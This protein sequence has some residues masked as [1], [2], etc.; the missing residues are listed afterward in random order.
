MNLNLRAKIKYLP[1]VGILL[2]SIWRYFTHRQDI[3][4]D[5][6]TSNR[7][8]N[9]GL[10]IK[11]GANDGSIGD[12]I[13]QLLIAYK[14]LKCV[15]VE[16]VPHLLARAKSI[17]GDSERFKYINN[18]IND[19]SQ[20]NFYFVDSEAQKLQNISVDPEQIG[21]FELSHILKHEGGRFA[22]FV[23]EIL[24]QGMTLQELLKN[25]I[26]VGIDLIHVDAEG[27]DWKIISQ[28]ELEKFR[29]TWIIFEYIHL[30]LSE[31]KAAVDKFSS[32]YEIKEYGTDY[33]C[34]LKKS[35]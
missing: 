13:S 25:Y 20:M 10:I 29:P 17:W 3:V 5:I 19:G 15:F 9:N 24:I 4:F 28:L 31:R 21:S 30:S 12:P 1:F 32:L 6:R 27:W 8:R 35:P 26:D 11:I 34:I 14:D 2:E 16:P 22:P 33:F 18:A 7:L 23:K